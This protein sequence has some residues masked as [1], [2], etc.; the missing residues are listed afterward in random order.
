MGAEVEGVE[1]DLERRGRVMLRRKER[2]RGRVAKRAGMWRNEGRKALRGKFSVMGEG[3]KREVRTGSI[4]GERERLLR[5]RPSGLQSRDS[6]E[7]R[8]W[9]ERT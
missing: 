7:R 6:C 9:A 2:K 5:E 3:A 1:V 4:G 8:S